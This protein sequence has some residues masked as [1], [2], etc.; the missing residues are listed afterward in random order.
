MKNRLVHEKHENHE[1]AG[2]VRLTAMEISLYKDGVLFVYFVDIMFF[3][4]ATSN[5]ATACA[6]M[7]SPRPI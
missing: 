4:L 2:I 5:K 7:P 1:Q 3:Y 6:A